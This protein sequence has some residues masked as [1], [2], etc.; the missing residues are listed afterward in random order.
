MFRVIS[1]KM[2]D[3]KVEHDLMSSLRF[4]VRKVVCRCSTEIH[5]W[6]TIWCKV[7]RILTTC[8]TLMILQYRPNL[9]QLLIHS[10]ERLRTFRTVKP[11]RN[12]SK[13]L[14]VSTAAQRASDERKCWV[15]LVTP[16]RRVAATILCWG[17]SIRTLKRSLSDLSKRPKYSKVS[18]AWI[19][20]RKGRINCIKGVKVC[21]EWMMMK[22]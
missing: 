8:N 12:E 11:W 18:D 21:S 6:R 22:V 5:T 10:D 19:E 17:K 16:V 7:T 4:R 13:Y 1:S 9:W 3:R 15:T 14:A 2:R 20:R